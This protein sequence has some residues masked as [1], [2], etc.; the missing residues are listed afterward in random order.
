M[1]WRL[2]VKGAGFFNTPAEQFLLQENPG[3]PLKDQYF[4]PESNGISLLQA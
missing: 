2:I 1:V 4:R 3:A